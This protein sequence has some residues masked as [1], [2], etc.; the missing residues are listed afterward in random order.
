MKRSN[1][2]M[3]VLAASMT[4]T[5]SVGLASSY[6]TTY[7]EASGGTSVVMKPTSTTPDESFSDWVKHVVITNNADT[8]PVYIRVKAFTGDAYQLNYSGNWTPTAD[9]YYVYNSIVEPGQDTETLDITI[10]NVPDDAA[11][12]TEFNVSVIYEATPVQYD[13][14][15]NVVEPV[16]ADWS[17]KLDTGNAEGGE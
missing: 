6:F 11:V 13:D 1:I 10:G 5:A 15:G 14:N 9:G 3:A 8:A 17:V 2:M 4:I 16:N 7:A 12:G